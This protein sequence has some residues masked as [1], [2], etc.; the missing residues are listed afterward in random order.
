M[1]DVPGALQPSDGDRH[2]S[3]TT[4]FSIGAPPKLDDDG[5][6]DGDRMGVVVKTWWVW[7]GTA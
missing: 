2:K 1:K 3:G 6:D 4:L 7:L 5:A